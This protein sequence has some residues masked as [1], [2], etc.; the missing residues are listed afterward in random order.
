MYFISFDLGSPVKAEHMPG[1]SHHMD[2]SDPRPQKYVKRDGQIDHVRNTVINFCA[3]TNLDV[4]AR[5]AFGGT[6]LQH[7]A[8]DH[9]Y[10]QRPFL[11]EIILKDIEVK[12]KTASI[13]PLIDVMSM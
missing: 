6:C 13:I 12:W 10:L 2:Y 4:S 11:E 9:D 8:M 7:A 5:Y 3:A 1:S